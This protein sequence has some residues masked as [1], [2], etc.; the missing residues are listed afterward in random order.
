MHRHPQLFN[1]TSESRSAMG[2]AGNA[3]ET[4]G[5]ENSVSLLEEQLYILDGQKIEHIGRDKAIEGIVRDVELH[6]A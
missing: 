4:T 2:E 1:E 5:L 3:Y 6:A